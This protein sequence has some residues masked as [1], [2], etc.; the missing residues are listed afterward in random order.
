[1]PPKTSAKKGTKSEDETKKKDTKGSK[2]PAEDTTGGEPGSVL[3]DTASSKQAAINVT[4]GTSQLGT[5]S[6]ENPNKEP[7]LST[8]ELS[9]HTDGNREIGE[10]GINLIDS[11]SGANIPEVEI[12][13]EEPILP[14][15]IVLKFVQLK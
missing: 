5:P 9:H 3:N 14:N 13:Y 6:E 10:G 15:L 12:K 4:R 1:M 11:S 2:K 8:S 7:G